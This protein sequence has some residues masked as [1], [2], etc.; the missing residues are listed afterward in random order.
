MRD[1]GIVTSHQDTADSQARN[2][3]MSLL[4]TPLE[5][6]GLTLTNRVVFGPM[7]TYSAVAGTAGDWHFSHLAR[8]AA[9]GAGLVYYEAT[10]TTRQARNIQGGAGIWQDEHVPPLLRITEFLRQQGTASAIQ[11]HHRGESGVVPRP[12]DGDSSAGAGVLAENEAFWDL[13]PGTGHALTDSRPSAHEYLRSNLERLQDSF[14]LAARRSAEAGFDVLEVHGGV[15]SLLH[16]FLSPVS[17]RRGDEYAGDREARMSFPLEVVERVRAVWPAERPLFYRL[18]PIDSAELSWR[19]DD[20]VEFAKALR[21]RGVDMISCASGGLPLCDPSSGAIDGVQ[22]VT[23]KRIREEAEVPTMTGGGIT[24]AA[25]AE[26]AL[27]DGCSDLV[28][29]VR[30]LIWNSNWPLHAAQELDADTEWQHWPLQ[31][32]WSLKQRSS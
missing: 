18:T 7:A 6:N 19:I 22:A 13:T 20:T 17:N 4:F 21:R 26:A 28:A 1:F 5:I 30:E 2:I 32:G 10:A 14:E 9:G 27:Q 23:A 11:L 16:S 15:G 24:K 31:Y 29:L 12:W 25:Q 3:R 8:F